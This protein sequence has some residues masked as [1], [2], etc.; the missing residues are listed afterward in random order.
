MIPRNSGRAIVTLAYGGVL[1]VVVPR[2][3]SI[4]SP[5]QS[6]MP[7]H[8]KDIGSLA[9]TVILCLP[10]LIGGIALLINS[11]LYQSI[12]QWEETSS[13]LVAL[14]VIAGGP[15]VAVAAIVGGLSA[16]SRSVSS[17]LKAAELLMICLA[18]IA[19]FCLLSR[20][21]RK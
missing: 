5:E 21:G 3:E 11:L 4:S 1:E 12:E 2:C 13:A 10:S 17:K 15:F 19:T 14:G 9:A 7:M 16:V 20:F 6:W 8:V 18:A